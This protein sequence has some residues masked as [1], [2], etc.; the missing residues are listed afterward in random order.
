MHRWEQWRGT[1][2]ARVTTLPGT[3]TFEV[4]S[5][6]LEVSNQPIS[7]RMIDLTTAFCHARFCRAAEMFATA[8]PGQAQQN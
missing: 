1:S 7:W 4:S 3:H 8:K 6:G 5:S 2:E